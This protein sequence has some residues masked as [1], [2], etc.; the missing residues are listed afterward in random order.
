MLFDDTE[1]LPNVVLDEDQKEL[2]TKA[3]GSAIFSLKTMYDCISKDQLLTGSLATSVMQNCEFSMRDLATI[4]QIETDSK[5]AIEERFSQI[6]TANLRIHELEKL[7]GS[8]SSEKTFQFQIKEKIARLKSW[9][10]VAGLGYISDVSLTEYG[11]EAEFSC[12]LSGD[13]SPQMTTKPVSERENKILWLADLKQRGFE[14]I[15]VRGQQSLMDSPQTRSVLI[16]L[17]KNT[18]PSSRILSFNNH[19]DPAGNYYLK[20]MNVRI[21]ASEEIE[22]LPEPSPDEW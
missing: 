12:H 13:F 11:M 14:M 3:I 9:W 6:R 1:D 17:L 15:K 21:A 18:L 4:L 2:A 7:L 10:R 20:S 19:L 5:T 22:Q 8:Q 16:D